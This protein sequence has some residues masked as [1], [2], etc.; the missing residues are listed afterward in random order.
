MVHRQPVRA[1]KARELALGVTRKPIVSAKPH[2]S[3]WTSRDRPNSARDQAIG[4]G[5]IVRGPVPTREAALCAK[6]HRSIGFAKET[7]NPAIHQSIL[8]GGQ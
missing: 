8:I 1:C 7:S 5:E 6:P 4:R 3:I 2:R